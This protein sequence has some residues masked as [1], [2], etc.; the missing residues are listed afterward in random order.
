MTSCKTVATLIIPTLLLMLHARPVQAAGADD[1]LIKQMEA[2]KLT[3]TKA[4]DAAETAS[5]GKA[6]AAHAK[7][8]DK[9]GQVL[10]FC[11]VGGTCLE[12]PVDIKSGA[13][14]NVTEATAKGEKSEH[15]TKAAEILKKLEE[16]KVT[17]AKAIETAETSTKGK[18]LLARPVL[19]GDKLDLKV[20]VY[21]DGKWQNATVDA[22]T[23]KVVKTEE[24][25]SDRKRDEKKSDEKRPEKKSGDRK[26]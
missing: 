19:E 6:I 26:P 13:A 21:A 8:V 5:N 7:T 24:A 20:R 2:A 11:V 10:V 25:R 9:V 12:V 3:L 23:G 16:G 15:V 17:L 22:K 1:E 4:V 18:A 14:G